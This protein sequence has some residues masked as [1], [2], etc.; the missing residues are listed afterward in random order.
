MKRNSLASKGLSMSQAQSISNLC[1]QRSKDITAALA[2]INNASKTIKIGK[3][4]Y[5][6]T[7]GK[8]MPSNVVELLASK[9]RL[10]ATQAFLMENIKAKDSIINEIKY[11]SFDF[12]AEN[13]SPT[14]EPQIMPE[15]VPQVGEDWGWEQLSE[16]EYNEF[17]EA[18]AYASH[19]GQ[20]IHK[21]GALDRL[22]TELPKIQT[23]EFM[24]LE[25]GKK[26][27]MKVT[28][29]HK[30]EGLLKTHEEL[31]AL[32]RGYEQRVNYFKSKVKNSVTKENARISKLNAEAQAEANEKNSLAMGE[33]TKKR[34]EWLAL[35]KKESHDF[36]AARQAR[37]E[38]AINLRIQVDERFQPVVDE[39]LKQLSE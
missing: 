5:V 11:E 33:Y 38:E 16:S 15:I 24:E 32:H 34:E 22:R 14:R 12:E 2:D 7:A 31:A 9:A 6:H 8:P 35:Y 28:V 1:N 26:S 29:H 4:D 27:P 18:E 13:P 20:F 23:L 19:I 21:G 36:E 10:H 30:P 17:I 25:I 3:E 37:I 39:F